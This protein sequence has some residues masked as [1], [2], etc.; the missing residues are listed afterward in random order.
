VT[1]FSSR[2]TRDGRAK[3]S[4]DSTKIPVAQGRYRLQMQAEV[5]I[6]KTRLSLDR[7]PSPNKAVILVSGS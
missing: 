4:S 6:L 1:D 3:V 5:A 2:F 7:Y